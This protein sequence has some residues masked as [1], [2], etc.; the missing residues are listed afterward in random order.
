MCFLLEKFADFNF[1]PLPISKCR[2]TLKHSDNN[3]CIFAG[4]RFHMIGI[5]IDDDNGVRLELF[6]VLIH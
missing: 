3:F 4:L 6:Q 2:V 5:A 1:S